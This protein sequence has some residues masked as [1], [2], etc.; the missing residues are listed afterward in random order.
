MSRGN[1]I[2]MTGQL[3]AT[4][5]TQAAAANRTAYRLGAGGK[6]PSRSGPNDSAGESDCVGFACWASGIDR[7]QE[8]DFP[9]WG[10]WINT[11]SAIESAKDKRHHATIPAI[12]FKLL[13][14]Y[15]VIET[16]DWILFNSIDED[17]DGKRDRVGHVGVVVDR[18]GYAT[19]SVFSAIKIA[20]CSPAN[21]VHGDDAIAIT[22]PETFAFG[23]N[24]TEFRGK[25]YPTK[26]TVFVRPA[27]YS[28]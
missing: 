7:F 2:A 4:R 24:R 13:G 9:Y 23:S 26:G 16:G 21:H 18:S 3:A 5:A 12:S 14:T 11:D 8:V 20:H 10:G 19:G 28:L 15:D 17:H 6:D 27:W 1:K 22:G 25:V